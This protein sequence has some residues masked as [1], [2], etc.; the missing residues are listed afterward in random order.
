MPWL[1]EMLWFIRAVLEVGLSCLGKKLIKTINTTH[2]G[3][4]YSKSSMQRTGLRDLQV[5]TRTTGKFKCCL[6]EVGLRAGRGG[7]GDSHKPFGVICLTM[8][9]RGFMDEGG[10]ILRL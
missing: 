10:S 1:L 3:F 4:Q 5:M 7:E 2:Q 6:W 8:G 9:I